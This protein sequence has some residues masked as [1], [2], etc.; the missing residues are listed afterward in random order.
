MDEVKVTHA[1]PAGL[2]VALLAF[3]API[4][5]R[6]AYR[7]AMGTF[8]THPLPYPEAPEAFR[9]A[10][11]LEVA[12]DPVDLYGNEVP[13]AHT[14]YRSDGAGGLYELHAPRVE[15]ARLG[16]PTS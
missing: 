2:L 8:S 12:E 13:R 10:P 15:I 4:F 11:Q 7:S 14:Q 1:V 6:D 16:S 5:A 9:R 3:A